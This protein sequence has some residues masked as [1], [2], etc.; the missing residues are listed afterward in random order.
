MPW[1]SIEQMLPLHFLQLWNIPLK[2]SEGSDGRQVFLV[3]DDVQCTIVQSFCS[4]VFQV[5]DYF[6]SIKRISLKGGR[7]SSVRDNKN[8]S[9]TDAWLY[10]ESKQ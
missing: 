6:E 1:S 8:I 3:S 4:H 2:S 10:D 9:Y 5:M 7:R